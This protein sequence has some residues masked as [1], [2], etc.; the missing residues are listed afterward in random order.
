MMTAI[1]NDPNIPIKNNII[2]PSIADAGWTPEDIFNTGYLSAYGNQLSAI[3]VEQYVFSSA[4][5]LS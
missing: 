4:L 3:A 1:Q 5:L 2:G